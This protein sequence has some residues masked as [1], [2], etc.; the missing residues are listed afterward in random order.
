MIRMKALVLF[1]AVAFAVSGCSAFFGFNAFAGLSTPPAPKAADYEG[2]G[3]LAK[4]Q[5]DLTSPAIIN[6]LKNDP[7][8]TAA[9]EAYL[10]SQIG[11]LTTDDQKQAAILYGDL[12]LKTTAG[13]ELVNNV[14]TTLVNGIPPSTKIQDLLGS[15]LPPA[16][17]ADINVFTPMV[18]ALLNACGPYLALG[19]SIHDLNANGV[20]DPGEGVPPGT[21]VGD[22]A[23]K[24]AVAWTVKVI[25]DDID[26]A[27]P[28]G[29]GLPLSQ[30]IGQMFLLSTNPASA[31]AAVQNIVPDPYTPRGGA[32]DTSLG[33]LG[34][35]FSCAGIPM[36]T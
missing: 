11:T 3:G 6:A 13:E 18:E 2:S 24:A 29:P 7:A 9:I 1:I 36:P 12:Y 10:L 21:N 5:Q 16:A 30:V 23:Q 31:D 22:V 27:L 32:F 33:Y 8:T 35:L 17:L 25:Y 28:G 34:N 20:I 19:A 4:L 14:V 26:A 15:I